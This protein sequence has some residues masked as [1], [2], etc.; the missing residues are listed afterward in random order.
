MCADPACTAKQSQGRNRA[1][2]HASAVL[3]SSIP[4]PVIDFYA[5]KL[6]RLALQAGGVCQ[7]TI[8][9]CGYSHSSPPGTQ[10]HIHSAALLQP[11]FGTLWA[12]HRCACECMQRLHAS[13]QAWHT[14]Q[15]LLY[16]LNRHLVVSCHICTIIHTG[17]KAAFADQHPHIYICH[18]A[19]HVWVARSDL[20]PDCIH[21]HSVNGLGAALG[22]F[23]CSL[24]LASLRLSTI[25]ASLILAPPL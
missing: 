18:S 24:R 8:M 10:T 2:Q 17:G 25:P 19:R 15:T 4:I 20:I 7:L 6:A 13:R 1:C 12:A 16:N 9:L 21:Q 23:P 11:F 14:C 5:K 22:P 3:G